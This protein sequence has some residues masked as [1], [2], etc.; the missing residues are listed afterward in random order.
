MG[1]VRETL[2]KYRYKKDPWGTNDGDQFG[3]FFVP[4]KIGTTPLKIVVAPFDSEMEWEHV[5]A[6]LPNRCPTW[7]E[8]C[9]VKHLFFEDHE[10]V[11]QFHPPLSEYVNNHPYCLHLWRN[12]KDEIKT[13]P[14]ILVGLK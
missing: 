5:S 12:K 11:I 14:S 13:P 10:T 7:E 8:M 2:N 1:L 4:Y 3:L 9:F 6:S